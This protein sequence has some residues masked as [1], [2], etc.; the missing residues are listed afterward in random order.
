MEP[1]QDLV[2]ALQQLLPR[3]SGAYSLVVMDEHRVIGVRD[4]YG[5][6]PLVL[7]GCRR[8]VVGKRRRL[9]RSRGPFPLPWDSPGRRAAAATRLG[10]RLGDR[11]ARRRLAPTSSATCEPGEMVVLGEPGGPRSVRFAEGQRAASACSS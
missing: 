2:E 8:A 5:F 4:P 3:V 9:S 1:A 6:R 11:R 10:A 7:A